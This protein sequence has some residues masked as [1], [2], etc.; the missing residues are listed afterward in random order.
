MKILNPWNNQRGIALVTSLIFMGFMTII[1][2]S[3]VVSA[4]SEFK[5]SRNFRVKKNALYVAE[6]GSEEARAR[7]AALAQAGTP[8][9]SWRT[10]VGDASEAAEVFGYNDQDSDHDINSSLQS[11]LNYTAV[12][13]HQTEADINADLDGDGDDSDIVLW[14][15]PNGDYNREKNI[16]DGDPV[17]MITSQGIV[18]GAV[19][20]VTVEARKGALFFEPPSALYVN[21][22]LIKNGSAGAAVGDYNGCTPMPDVIT[23]TAAFPG[24]EASNWP[25]ATSAPP[26]LVDDESKIY[27]IVQV[28]DEACENADQMVYSGNNQTFGTVG[29]PTGVYCSNGDWDGSNLDGYGIL[30][31]KG[32]FVVSGNIAWHGII[33]ATGISVFNG[34]G[35]KEI[36][37]AV[38]ANAFATL[39]GNPEIYYDCDMINML[40]NAHGRYGAYA[41]NDT[42]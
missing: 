18:G 35:S 10:F 12:I 36:Y 11:D 24:F 5:S 16:T 7:M 1:V 13:R 39:N 26:W 25:A 27:P 21:G 3:F 2:T 33:F 4:S 30:A 42:Q 32:N 31:I 22:P 34:G 38:M 29:N 41:W 9:G 6:A 17:E 8:S 23:T 15:D 40:K 20:T 28:V 37:G 19:K 14:G